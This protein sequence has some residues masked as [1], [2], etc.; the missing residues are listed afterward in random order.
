MR[1][2]NID[3]YTYY[4]DKS[5][6]PKKL[7]K[8]KYI[9]APN[10]AV[11]DAKEG[12][13]PKILENL[14]KERQIATK[15][16]NE[17]ARY[18]IKILMN[19]FFGALASPKCRFSTHELGDSITSFAQKIIKKTRDLI[20]EEGY[21]VIYGDTDSIFIDLHVS[22]FEKAKKI[23]EKISDH[24]NDY[25]KNWIK[26]EFARKSFLDLEF[27]KTYS[28]FLIPYARGSKTGAKKRYAGL[29]MKNGKEDSIDFT[30]L[31]FVRRDWTEVSK[32]FQLTLL[33]KVFHKQEVA[34]FVKQFV[35]DLKS[36]K[37]DDKLVYKKALRKNLDDYTKTTPPHVKAAKKLDKLESNIVEY[38]I[39]VDGP[40]P[41]QNLKHSIDY[42]HYIKKQIKP[43]ADSVLVFFDQSFDDVIKGSTQK[44]LFGY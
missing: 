7:H 11:F 4:Y 8:D 42:D 20:E 19:S 41:V 27:E 44:N 32:V 23:G 17:L 34:G 31:E 39:T 1:T 26:D 43:I 35:K 14:F 28:R 3:P 21:D 9:K 15:N 24:I 40:E 13:L 33:D 12:I 10:G 6:L 30:G 2:F 37:Y 22:S 25:F 18:A 5:D 16:K 38:Y 36:G 29:L